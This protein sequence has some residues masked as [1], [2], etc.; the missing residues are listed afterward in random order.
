MEK[1]SRQE[2]YTELRAIIWHLTCSR[3]DEMLE[4]AIQRW[5]DREAEKLQE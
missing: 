3:Q 1:K 2:I 4:K 5:L